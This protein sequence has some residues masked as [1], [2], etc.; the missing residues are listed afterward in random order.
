MT[1]VMIASDFSSNPRASRTMR[2]VTTHAA[3]VIRCFMDVENTYISM[4]ACPHGYHVK[5]GWVVTN[6]IVIGLCSPERSI[7]FSR[8]LTMSALQPLQT[9]RAKS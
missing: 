1:M 7:H 9:T 2:L 4:H 8:F 5:I 3:S 6:D